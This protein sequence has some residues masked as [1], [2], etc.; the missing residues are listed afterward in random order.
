MT[1]LFD[2]AEQRGVSWQE[3]AHEEGQAHEEIQKAEKLLEY[4][5][6]LYPD[7]EEVKEILAYSSKVFE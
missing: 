1:N 2:R 5:K 6:S 7:W 3:Q 4:A